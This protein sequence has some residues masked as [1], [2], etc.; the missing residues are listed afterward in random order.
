M[1]TLQ[2]DNEIQAQRDFFHT[3]TTKNTQFRIAQLKKLQ[4]ILKQNESK[5]AEAIYLDFGKSEFDFFTTEM[6]ILYSDIAES[7]KKI[8]SWSKRKRV[9]TNVVNLPGKSYI[10]PEPLGVSLIIGAWNY[11]YQ[12]CFSPAIAAISAGCTV[13]LK[14]SELPSRTSA[15]MA[16]IINSNF[17][18]G[19]FRVIEGG[20]PEMTALLNQRYDK[21][22][23]TGSIP[24][25][26]IVYQAAAKNLTPVTLELG[27]KSPAFVTSSCNLDVTVRRLVWAKYLNAGQTCIAPDYIMV[28]AAIKSTFIEKLI[29]EIERSDFSVQN[30]NY[31][32]IINERNYDR[33]SS[34]L[35]T[36]NIHYGGQMDREKRHISPTLLTDVSFDDT[37]MQEE[38]FGPILP[39]LT[40]TNLDEAIQHVKQRPKPLSLY[41]FS[42]DNA[43]RNKLLAAISF[44]GGAVNDAIMH[45]ANPHLPFGGVGDSGMGSYHGQAGFKAFSHEKSIFQKSN[46]FE[47]SLK[48]SPHTPARFKWIK[49]LMTWM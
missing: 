5:M 35:D 2:F 34:L 18:P 49:R 43:E 48:Y 21:I 39:I 14:P 45:I 27:G 13:V 11:P 8:N 32:Q 33:L 47:P 25:G 28:D 20:V 4:V 15:V 36:K 30:G 42:T 16:E 7:I 9:R 29:Q 23:F 44:G 31:V 19:F 41:V 37:I 17:D 38:I 10:I 12:L 26:K 40:Y 3:D 22:F 1:S 6:S 24:V 46:Y